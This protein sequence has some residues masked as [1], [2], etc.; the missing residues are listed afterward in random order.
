MHHINSLEE[1]SSDHVLV[2]TGRLK[3]AYNLHHG[4]VKRLT[5]KRFVIGPSAAVVNAP[6]QM[7][8]VRYD[9]YGNAQINATVM[10]ETSFNNNT[11]AAAQNGIYLSA[12]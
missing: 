8:S 5:C 1:G 10:S 9:I 3:P 4:T 7:N 6:G 11:A 12:L 2:H